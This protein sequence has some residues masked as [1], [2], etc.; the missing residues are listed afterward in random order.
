MI[1]PETSYTKIF[2]NELRFLLVTHMTCFDIW[3]GHYGILKSDFS[4]V[5]ILDRL[6]IRCLI[7]FLGHKM[8]ETH[9]GLNT[10]PGDNKLRLTTPTQTHIFDNRSNGYDRLSIAHM[11]SSVSR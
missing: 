9:W 1:S 7:R 6:G 2:A 5:Q 10:S 4:S 11:R 8:S 3:F